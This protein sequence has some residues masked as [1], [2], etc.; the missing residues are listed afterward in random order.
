MKVQWDTVHGM[1][2]GVVVRQ[3]ENGY[4]LVE[5]K[6]RYVPIHQNSVKIVE[7]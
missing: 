5:Y 3:L 1:L 2:E 6:G 7:I 4:I